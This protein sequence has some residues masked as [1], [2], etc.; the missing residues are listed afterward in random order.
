M[1]NLNFND[2]KLFNAFSYPGGERQVRLTAEGIALVAAGEGT[3]V[4]AV[5]RSPQ[6]IIDLA[7]L[8]D[9]MERN[10]KTTVHKWEDDP[11]ILEIP[12]LPY[13]R[14]DRCFVDGDCHGLATFAKLLFSMSWHSIR[15]LDAHNPK[16]A[17]EWVHGLI[18]HPANAYIRRAVEGFS[19][20]Y[21][22]REVTVILPDEGAA[23]R[24]SLP[25][26]YG[27]NTY[28]IKV[29]TAHCTKRRDAAT[30]TLSGFEVPDVSGGAIIVDD[31]CD[32]GGT[33]KGIGA[34][35]Q[36][37]P[38]GLY[39]THG[40]FSRGLD[41]LRVIFDHIY[42]TNSYCKLTGSAASQLTIFPVEF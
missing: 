15:T 2:S 11:F 7:L 35:L 17:E 9:A 25:N 33:F 3:T 14:A 23:K 16:V 36:C 42:T 12:Y 24:Y 28:D 8:K 13:G 21:S 29:K 22:L 20:R 4:R 34:Q 18:N 1:L 31:L 5:L 32:G 10:R 39:V 37:K 38:L 19:K 40:L 26:F 30:G 6:D 41:E 27:C